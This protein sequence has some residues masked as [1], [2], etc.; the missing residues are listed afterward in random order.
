[1]YKVVVCR[2]AARRADLF[3]SSPNKEDNGKNDSN[4]NGSSVSCSLESTRVDL[5]GLFDLDSIDLD[6][7]VERSGSLSSK[8]CAWDGSGYNRKSGL[9]GEGSNIVDCEEGSDDESKKAVHFA[10]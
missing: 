6:L 9:A 1:M 4:G 8:W 5:L 3:G 10:S 7:E 2:A